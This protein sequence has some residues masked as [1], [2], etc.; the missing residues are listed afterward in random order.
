MTRLW[1]ALGASAFTLPIFAVPLAAQQTPAG[2]TAPS[3]Y[4][5][6]QQVQTPRT[7]QPTAGQPTANRQIPTGQ[8]QPQQAQPQ[9]PTYGP[10]AGGARGP[11]RQVAGEEPIRQP[12]AGRSPDNPISIPLSQAAAAPVQPQ[13]P[14]WV[15]L[16]P[17]HEK[18]ISDVL[19]YWEEHSN[20][21]QTLACQFTR[22]EYD[23]VFGPQDP[24]TAKT[25]AVGEIKY[26][27]PD[28]GLFKVK[29]LHLYAP[30]AKTGEKPQYVKQDAMFGEHWI[31]DG[32]RVFEFDG[33]NKRL[34]ERELPPE[35]KGKAIADGPLPFLFGA[36]A[37]TIQA[38]Y[39]IRGLPQSGSGKYWLEAV[40][41]S[42]QDRQ[43]FKAVT[44]VLDEKT[45]LPE[46]IEVLAPNYDAATNPA[47]STYQL[48]K[49]ETTDKVAG[50][51]D[52]FMALFRKSFDKPSV[53]AGW[54]KF[55]ERADGTTAGGPTPGG[56]A[57]G[58]AAP[59]VN[60]ALEATR[61][62]APRSQ[63]PR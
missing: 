51:L 48:A 30:P 14:S 5:P 50:P 4:G 21:I 61:P 40:P 45:Y 22:W 33:R 1:L 47:R 36:R 59:G 25:I 31:S 42:I 7:A 10:S 39:W 41:K 11:V 26:A 54:T 8:A 12:G 23:P 35:M 20:K 29:E 63:L 58:G 17:A 60:S 32:E 49:H 16:D 53:P 57:P 2:P 52:K 6:P 9:R 19:R 28:K 56:V 55:V 27:K 34:I 24:K 43:N 44:I 37:E 13:P 15:P 62:A 18:W 38:R 3:R 46:V